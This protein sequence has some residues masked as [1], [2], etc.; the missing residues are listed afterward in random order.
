MKGTH[1]MPREF[2]LSFQDQPFA[3]ALGLEGG[4]PSCHFVLMTT[5]R[6]DE[7]L[8]LISFMELN[9]IP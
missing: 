8:N 6:V 4:I 1:I 3:F 7:L 2:Q 9:G 5:G